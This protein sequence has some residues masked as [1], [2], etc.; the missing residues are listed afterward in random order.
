M[1]WISSRFESLSLHIRES[2]TVKKTRNGPKRPKRPKRQVAADSRIFVY[3]YTWKRLQK[4]FLKCI[5][6]AFLK[7]IW[8]QTM[9]H[10][11]LSSVYLHLLK[12]TKLNDT[13]VGSQLSAVQGIHGRRWRH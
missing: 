5:F 9:N 7:N 10:Q 4:D 12:I 6:G 2:D 11:L 13:S 3:R 1:M 8:S